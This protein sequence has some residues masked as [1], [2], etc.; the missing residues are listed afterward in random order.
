MR[1][2]LISSARTLWKIII[3]VVGASVILFGVALFFTPGPAIVVI[4]L[5]LAILATEFVWAAR[6]LRA[7]KERARAMMPRRADNGDDA[8]A[9]PRTNS[10]ER[11]RRSDPSQTPSE[12]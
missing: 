6:V 4:P 10:V 8:T 7:F 11:G 12:T 1:R 9:R 2:V 3:A 5:G